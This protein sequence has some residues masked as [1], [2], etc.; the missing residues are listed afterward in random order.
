MLLG[1]GRVIS[2]IAMQTDSDPDASSRR[3]GH[4]IGSSKQ[5]T[6]ASCGRSIAEVVGFRIMRALTH[7]GIATGIVVLPYRRQTFFKGF[8]PF[9]VV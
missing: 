2:Q 6:T 8:L 9:C 5:L 1:T 3:D 4:P 7:S